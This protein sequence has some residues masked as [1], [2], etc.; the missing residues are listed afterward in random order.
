M[1]VTVPTTGAAAVTVIA[2][3]ALFPPIVTVTVAEPA[4]TPVTSPEVEMVA[5]P[6]FALLHVA[7]RPESTLPP[8]SFAVAVNC[9]VC[10]AVTDTVAG[11]TRTCA[12]AM[13]ATTTVA[14]A[15]LPLTS[16]VIVAD[17]VA[18]AVT[19]PLDDTVA[20]LVFELVHV[21]GGSPASGLLFPSFGVAVSCT[22]WPADK[23]S[24]AG[25][26]ITLLTGGGITVID[27]LPVLP[28]VVADTVASP[29]ATAV[30]RPL[31]ETVSTLLLLLLHAMVW[32][33][34]GFPPASST[35]PVNWSVCPRLRFAEPGVTTTDATGTGDTVTCAVP[36][37]PPLDAEMV[38]VP[39]VTPVTNPVDEMVATPV[40]A[41]LQV[42]VR[43]PSTFPTESLSV[44]DIC[45]VRPT[46]TV[47][48]V[49]VTATA[50]MDAG[51]AATTVMFAVPLFPWLVAV[52][53]AAPMAS[54]EIAPLAD[55]VATL[56]FE[57]DHTT[58]APATAVPEASVA[59]A[60]SCAEPPGFSETDVGDTLTVATGAGAAAVTLMGTVVV[61]PAAETLTLVLPMPIS[62]TFPESETLAT[63][64]LVDAQVKVWPDMA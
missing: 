20:T 47:A 33:P 36:V 55:T 15:N 49:G 61:R 34:N 9:A 13:G 18:T 45:V 54:A 31:E 11:A 59:E 62:V 7:A 58:V 16:T 50:P 8:A 43:P 14:F 46:M 41:L 21:P 24:V 28:L 22:V 63:C 25:A 30:T 3:L 51:D 23:V 19:N 48:V 35:V 39:V 12:T 10:P 64:V 2:A 53:T 44:A 56:V 27:A 42:T 57:E 6:V 29:V 5:T 26:T 60:L 1:T 40:L 17:P 37:R 52:I 38:T 4:P 32:P